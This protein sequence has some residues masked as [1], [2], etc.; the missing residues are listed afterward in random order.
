MPGCVGLIMVSCL[1][2]SVPPFT[3]GVYLK[4]WWH[5]ATF[6]KTFI[7]FNIHSN[8]TI[9]HY[10]IIHPRPVFFYL[11]HFSALQEKPPW[12]A[13]PGIKLGPAAQQADKL[14]FEPHRTLIEPCRSLIEPSPTLIEPHHTLIVP[15]P[16][17]TEPRYTLIE[18]R[19]TLIQPCCTLIEPGRT[20]IEPC[21][22]LIE[23]RRTLSGVYWTG[24][25]VKLLASCILEF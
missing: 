1:F 12:G 6:L 7:I 17:L 9:I 8:N 4:L 18:P 16:T 11:H 23:P 20:L 21:R 25:N 3:S 2:L 15:N 13:E 24:L 14:P 10:F 22:T 5:Y 19:R